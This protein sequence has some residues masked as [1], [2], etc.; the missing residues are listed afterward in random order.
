MDPR[1]HENINVCKSGISILY[2]TQNYMLYFSIFH[3]NV[4]V[5]WSV[6]EPHFS[7]NFA[8]YNFPSFISKFWRQLGREKIK[9]YLVNFTHYIFPSP[10]ACVGVN[11]IKKGE[12][13]LWVHFSHYPSPPFVHNVPLIFINPYSLWFVLVSFSLTRSDFIK[14]DFF[15]PS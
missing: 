3:E 1:I 14:I 15:L 4:N 9:L 11:A 2:L 7:V 6:M 8:Y 13:N 12:T 10:N 5:N